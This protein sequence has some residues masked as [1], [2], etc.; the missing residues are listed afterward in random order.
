MPAGLPARAGYSGR[1]RRGVFYGVVAFGLAVGIGAAAYVL[2]TGGSLELAAT[3]L[4]VLVGALVLYP[5]KFAAFRLPPR[6]DR[7]ETL[8]VALVVFALLVAAAGVI[9]GV[10]GR[11]PWFRAAACLVTIAVVFGAAGM[12]VLR[13]RP[14][15][16]AISWRE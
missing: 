6:G 1:V 16:D 3:I 10:V 9:V 11:S 7:R 13:R 5:L 8:G 2:A 15:A 12:F 14:A 4:A